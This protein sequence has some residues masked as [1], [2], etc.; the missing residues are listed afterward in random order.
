MAGTPTNAAAASGGL[1]VRTLILA[2]PTLYLLVALYLMDNRRAHLLPAVSTVPSRVLYM[3]GAQQALR[4]QMAPDL[5]PPVA[6]AEPVAAPKPRAAQEAPAA[7]APAAAAGG[8]LVQK[9][10]VAPKLVPE[11]KVREPDRRWLLAGRV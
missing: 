9:Y 8:P 3:G 7:A 4:A 1:S 2:L 6:A 10:S 5:P 11:D